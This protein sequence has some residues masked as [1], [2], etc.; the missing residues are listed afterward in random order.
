MNV[1]VV[2]GG[3]TGQ[4][5]VRVHVES[6]LLSVKTSQRFGSVAVNKSKRSTR[7]RP[8]QLRESTQSTTW[9]TMVKLSQTKIR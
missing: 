8:G 5:V 9:S 3:S 7:V 2:D 4:I 6:V 1:V